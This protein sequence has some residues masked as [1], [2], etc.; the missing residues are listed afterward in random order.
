MPNL[1]KDATEVI[2]TA[3]GKELS[4]PFEEAKKFFIGFSKDGQAF[5]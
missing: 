1:K 2:V 4:F 5:N 3:D